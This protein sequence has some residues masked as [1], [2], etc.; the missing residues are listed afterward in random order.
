MDRRQMAIQQEAA[1]RQM[2]TAVVEI[3]EK[4]GIDPPDF[5]GVVYTGGNEVVALQRLQILADYLA[6]VAQVMPRARR[7]RAQEIPG[8]EEQMDGTPGEGIQLN[9][10]DGVPPVSSAEEPA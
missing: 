10:E 5:D 4:L 3:G 8:T 7:R 6:T 1:Q 2:G 9:P